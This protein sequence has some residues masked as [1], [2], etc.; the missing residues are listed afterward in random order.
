MSKSFLR[1]QLRKCCRHAMNHVLNEVDENDLGRSAI[2]FAPHP[3]DETLG[4]GG[5]IIKKKKAGAKVKIFF[6]TDG[7][8][9]HPHLI[10]EK[11]LKSI[12]TN[13]AIAAS[14]MLG[15]EK[16]DAVFLDFEDGKL[17]K[18]QSSAIHKVIE[19]LLDKQPDQIFIPYYKEPSLWSNDHLATN[20]IVLS[21]LQ[22]YRRN[23]VI[24]EYPI[25]FWYHW[26]WTNISIHC[27]Q[28]FLTFL[29]NSLVSPFSFLKDFRCS[30]Y[31][32]DVLHLKHA[33]LEQHKSQMTH[34]IPDPRWWTLGDISN[35]EFLECFFQEHEVF[36]RYNFHV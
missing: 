31:I 26:P 12:R 27:C 14:R 1:A 28:E 20:R 33:A 16:N 10:S 25:W 5:T 15:V 17:S 30:V 9:S 24:Y 11:E 3:D 7:Q 8:R 6:M 19:I 29:K 18:N 2:V 4:C 22:P 23:A 21:A 36:Y 35:G 34:L 32:G 13:E